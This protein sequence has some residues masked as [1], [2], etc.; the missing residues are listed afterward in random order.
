MST[1]NPTPNR[2]EWRSYRLASNYSYGPSHYGD[3]ET[4]CEDTKHCIRNS[5]YQHT[6]TTQ[7]SLYEPPV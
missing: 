3:M 2:L 4:P 7:W 1:T 5:R 6:C